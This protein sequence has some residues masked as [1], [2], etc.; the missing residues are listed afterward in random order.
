M[1]HS[2]P[3]LPKFQHLDIESI[4]QHLTTLFEEHKAKLEDIL[5]KSQKNYTW[6]N[7]MSPL[8][9]MSDEWHKI[10]GPLAHLNGVANTKK[11]REAYQKCLPILTEYALTFSHHQALYEATQQ[12]SESSEFSHLSHTKQKIIRDQLTDFKLAGIALN[13]KDK[14]R[15]K[16]IQ[17]TLSELCN[18]FEN[19]LI[20]ATQAW[21]KHVEDESILSGIPPHVIQEAAELAKKES[22]SGWL[23]SLEPPVYQAIMMYADHRQLREDFHHAYVTRASKLS[24]SGVSWDNSQIMQDILALRHEEALLLGYTNYCE[25]SLARKMAETPKQVFDFLDTLIQKVKPQAE[26]ES[27][28]LKSYAKEKLSLSPLEP[29]DTGY[30]TEKLR[31]AEYAVSQNEF[32]PYLPHCFVLEGL[33]NIAG[34][35]Y[36]MTF[37]QIEHVEDR[38]SVV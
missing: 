6:E 12:L 1:N 16:V 14:E 5:A 32:R 38:K 23:F 17:Q 36:G 13:S 28:R 24:P 31:E 21:K 4:P 19:H 27:A 11:I 35:L 22:L 25:L 15:F 34:K 10:I 3:V 9:I 26:E 2:F 29:W 37:K 20:D 7:L 8:E 30:A 18:Q 33:F